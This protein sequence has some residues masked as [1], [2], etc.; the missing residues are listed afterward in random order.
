M[1][2]H[3]PVCVVHPGREPLSLGG[4]EQH[5]RVVYAEPSLPL[6]S[7][8]RFECHPVI[9]LG[10]A[11]GGPI[12]LRFA[13]E[14]PGSV[15]GLVLYSPAADEEDLSALNLPTLIVTGAHDAVCSPSRAARLHGRI[16]GSALLVLPGSGSKAHLSQPVPFTGAVSEF[17]ELV[18]DAT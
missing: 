2:N 13:L 4:V 5:V 15:A 17:I 1:R 7:P 14:H 12:V 6:L 16:R 11:S 8:P 18:T 9:L 10:H 3:E